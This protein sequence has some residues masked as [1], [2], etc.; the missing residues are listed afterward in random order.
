METNPVL[1]DSMVPALFAVDEADAA[2]EEA[3]AAAALVAKGC[4]LVGC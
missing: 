2:E 3:E 4:L 1:A